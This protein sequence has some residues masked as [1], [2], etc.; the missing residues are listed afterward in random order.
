MTLKE[1]VLNV[2]ELASEKDVT[3]VI[4]WLEEAMGILEDEEIT[5]TEVNN[6]CDRHYEPSEEQMFDWIH[7]DGDESPSYIHNAS[8]TSELDNVLVLK[9]GGCY[10]W[11]DIYNCQ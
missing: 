7:E 9:N 3:Q 1:C 2:F 4:T 11:Y 8:W 5:D 6:I 10:F